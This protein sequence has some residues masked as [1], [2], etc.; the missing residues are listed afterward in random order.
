[1]LKFNT[2]DAEECVREIT[3]PSIFFSSTGI[4][5]WRMGKEGCYMTKP[6]VFNLTKENL[7]DLEIHI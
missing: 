3:N 7:M 6:Q 2:V 4:Y 1:M 5:S